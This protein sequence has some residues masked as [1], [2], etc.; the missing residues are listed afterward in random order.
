[1]PEFPIR[2]DLFDGRQQRWRRLL[3]DFLKPRAAHLIFV[4]LRIMKDVQ[5]EQEFKCQ[6]NSNVDP[7]QSIRVPRQGAALPKPSEPRQRA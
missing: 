3:A 2:R 5:R 7:R 6:A 4:T 1:M